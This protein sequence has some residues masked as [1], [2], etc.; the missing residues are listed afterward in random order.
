MKMNRKQI[1]LFT[2]I[3]LL[4]YV[5]YHVP[6]RI[7]CPSD[8]QIEIDISGEQHLIL[9]DEERDE[10]ILL[11]NQ[12][13]I[14]RRFTFSHSN[15][16]GEPLY[17]DNHTYVHVYVDGDL[18]RMKYQLLVMFNQNRVIVQ[19]FFREPTNY[20]EVIGNE[21]VIKEFV[22]TIQEKAGME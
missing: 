20:K 10:A 11:L 2:F 14:R 5:C 13:M 21:A 8:C 12:L 16:A 18:H 6:F 17:D 3:I 7:D 19:E 22:S 9:S 15:Y 1:G 4:F